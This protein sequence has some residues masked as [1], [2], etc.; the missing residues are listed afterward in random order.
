[1][2]LLRRRWWFWWG[3]N[4]SSSWPNA[5]ACYVLTFKC[6][7]ENFI[8]ITDKKYPMNGASQ[9]RR[10]SHQF[11]VPV[12][13][14]RDMQCFSVT[15]GKKLLLLTTPIR[16]LVNYLRYDA[17]AFLDSHTLFKG[18]SLINQIN[19]PCAPLGTWLVSE[20][21]SSL[22]D[23]NN[24]LNESNTYEYLY[25][26]TW[27]RG[28]KSFRFSCMNLNWKKPSFTCLWTAKNSYRRHNS[29]IKIKKN[30]YPFKKNQGMLQVDIQHYLFFHYWRQYYSII[31]WREKQLKQ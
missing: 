5:W 23:T 20:D 31:Q 10:I 9:V 2:T 26:W 19:A 12:K 15:T 28:L 25:C 16:I 11:H 14:Y 24:W 30:S 17:Y 27:T 18:Y 3:V 4:M 6:K 1:M 21:K 7:E 22:W 8:T 29:H 13:K